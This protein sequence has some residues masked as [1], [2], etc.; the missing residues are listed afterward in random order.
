MEN[1]VV[2]KLAYIDP[3]NTPVDESSKPEVIKQADNP[4][5][6]KRLSER[7]RRQNGDY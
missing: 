3:P 5:R 1:I 6:R 7:Q 4:S 2:E